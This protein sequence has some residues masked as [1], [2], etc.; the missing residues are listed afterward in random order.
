MLSTHLL[1]WAT[2][3]LS[4]IHNSSRPAERLLRLQIG[5]QD[6]KALETACK[7]SCA[8]FGDF[9]RWCLQKKHVATHVRHHSR[10]SLLGMVNLIDQTHFSGLDSLLAEPQGVILALPH[11]GHYIATA[12]QLME[13]IA[14][15]RDVYMLYGDPARHPG[16]EVFDRL[17][18]RLFA[19]PARRQYAIHSD[20]AG[21]SSALR[22]LRAGA[23]L[24]MMPD[25]YLRR[26]DTFAVPFCGRPLDIMLGTAAIARRANSWIL[27]IVS[28]V[29]HRLRARTV[30]GPLLDAQPAAGD[31]IGMLPDVVDYRTMLT[32]FSY[33]ESVMEPQ[34][35]YWQHVRQ[36]LSK[37]TPFPSLAVAEFLQTWELFQKDARAQVT[38]A[39]A[40]DL[41]P[42]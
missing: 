41:D 17:D 39:H 21:M 1:D 38:T 40:I 10:S 25:V 42:S 18:E 14:H 19:A 22:A 5:A 32:M 35:I 31:P 26:E 24:I 20:R 7:M 12:V 29:D 15:T 36:H 8:G 9:Y 23:A 28:T 6:K 16:N 30:W 37:H 33:F 2:R 4:L 13:H 3:P 27:P 34:I 11:H